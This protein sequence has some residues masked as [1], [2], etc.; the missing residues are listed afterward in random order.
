MTVQQ[1]QRGHD[2]LTVNGE[3]FTKSC[4]VSF[5][6]DKPQPYTGCQYEIEISDIDSY[7]EIN[8]DDDVE[9][10]QRDDK[11]NTVI[12]LDRIDVVEYGMGFESDLMKIFI[13]ARGNHKIVPRESEQNGGC[14]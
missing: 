1:R 13:E 2:I 3:I 6:W 9:I 4:T 14:R 5:T 12:Q 11:E 8:M 10:V 7:P